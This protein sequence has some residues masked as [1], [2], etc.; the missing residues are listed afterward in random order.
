MY[1]EHIGI[2]TERGRNKK[3]IT[4]EAGM[5]RVTE[6]ENVGSKLKAPRQRRP[7]QNHV[8]CANTY[9]SLLDYEEPNRA[10]TKRLNSRLHGLGPAVQDC[11]GRDLRSRLLFNTVSKPFQTGRRPVN[12]QWRPA[13]YL[14][15]HSFLLNFVNTSQL[16][17][18]ARTRRSF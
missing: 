13:S 9:I 11:L 6:E 3:N 4:L 12:K 7:K 8:G 2:F 15:L 18:K 16:M 10:G 17:Q 1:R 14:G 5:G